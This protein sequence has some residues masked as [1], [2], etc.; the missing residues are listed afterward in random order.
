MTWFNLPTLVSDNPTR[1]PHPTV[2]KTNSP[3][4]KATSPPT[5]GKKPKPITRCPHCDKQFSSNRNMRE[6]IQRVHNKIRPY[7][8]DL[9]DK[10]FFTNSD[11]KSHQ[12]VHGLGIVHKEGYL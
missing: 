4:P 7:K 5:K 8:C 12:A 9:C 11:L 6:H 3:V 1:N 2:A 10:R